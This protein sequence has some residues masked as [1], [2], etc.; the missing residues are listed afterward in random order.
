MNPSS[1]FFGASSG[2]A[3]SPAPDAPK[4]PITVNPNATPQ[5]IMEAWKQ[6]VL[7]NRESPDE[8]FVEQFLSK[9]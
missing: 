4:P 8:A 9:R 3:D 6:S 1:A 7:A 2:G 5:E